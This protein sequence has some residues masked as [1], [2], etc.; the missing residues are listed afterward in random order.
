[1]DAAKTDKNVRLSTNVNFGVSYVFGQNEKHALG[2]AVLFGLERAA[3]R[4]KVERA[5]V[6]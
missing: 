5:G 3:H 4:Q 1:M 6:K 2:G